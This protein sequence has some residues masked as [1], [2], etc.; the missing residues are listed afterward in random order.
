MEKSSYI[1]S[2]KNVK[3]NRD[4]KLITS[5]ARRNYVISEPNYYTKKYQVIY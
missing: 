3:N 1:K 4:I 5:E 2:I